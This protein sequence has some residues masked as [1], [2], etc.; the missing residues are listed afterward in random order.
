MNYLYHNTTLIGLDQIYDEMFRAK[1]RTKGF[2]DYLRHEDL[3]RQ[4]ARLKIGEALF[5]VFFW[6][7]EEIARREAGAIPGIVTLRFPYD[8]EFSQ[9]Y[10]R[11]QDPHYPFG[12][13]CAFWGIEQS[14]MSYSREAVPLCNADVLYN[15]KWSSYQDF[16]RDISHLRGLLCLVWPP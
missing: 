5:A 4:F 1:R 14:E 2:F 9:R 6:S 11:L 13:A 8:N 3:Y 12:E 10:S 15:G 16:K 7:S